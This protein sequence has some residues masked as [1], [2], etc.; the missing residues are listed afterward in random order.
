MKNIS[1]NIINDLLPLY[2]EN[3]L[4]EDS[5]KLV[6]EHMEQC[7]SC[8][9]SLEN[10]KRPIAT[11]TV[12]FNDIKPLEKIKKKNHKIITIII[13]AAVVVTIV[14]NLAVIGIAYCFIHSDNVILTQDISDYSAYVGSDVRSDYVPT[15][16]DE[17]NCRY[18]YEIFPEELPE[19]ASVS[20]FVY[21]YYN[22][23]DPNY[24]VYLVYDCNEQDFENECE[25]LSKI[26]SSE[27][28]NYYGVTGFPYELEAVLANEYYGF[29]YCLSDADNH[30][31]IYV[32]IYH[33]NYFTDIDYKKY[34]PE[35]YLPLGYDATDGNNY[36]KSMLSE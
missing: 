35:E 14:L 32:Q 31:L 19:S 30:R 25:R 27:R 24:L 12:N 7:E 3:M 1:C 4:S 13:I 5:K 16:Y 21:Y 33:C 29:T 23:W 18:L 20:D 26:S 34:I 36:R 11:N 17:S 28:Y 2:A 22:P 8:R 10:L 15:E 6:E 9:N